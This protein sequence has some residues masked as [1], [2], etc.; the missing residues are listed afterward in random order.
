MN[1]VF[2]KEEY[3]RIFKP[4]DSYKV[5]PAYFEGLFKGDDINSIWSSKVEPLLR[6][7]VRGRDDAEMFI[8]DCKTALT[9]GSNG[10]ESY[11]FLKEIIKNIFG[12]GQAPKDNIVK[13]FFEGSEDYNTV[14]NKIKDKYKNKK[15]KDNIENNENLKEEI[16]QILSVKN[17][18]DDEL[19]LPSDQNIL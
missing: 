9:G 15:V 2:E 17:G 4:A 5:G 1:E 12:L 18:N 8:L 13:K 6:E 11:K 3:Q 7:Y 10:D 16:E 14:V 19:G